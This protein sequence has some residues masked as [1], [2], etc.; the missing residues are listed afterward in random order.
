[1]PHS[2]FWQAFMHSKVAAY[3]TRYTTLGKKPASMK[4]DAQRYRD[5]FSI[6]T[7]LRLISMMHSLGWVCL[8]E[9]GV[10]ADGRKLCLWGCDTAVSV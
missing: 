8:L 10:N 1:M 6:C 5:T 2:A 4:I 9:L 7:L 3:V